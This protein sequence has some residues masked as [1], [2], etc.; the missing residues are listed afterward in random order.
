MRVMVIVKAS[1][2]SEAGLMP[3][4]E[5]LLAM[6]RFNEELMCAGVLLAGEGLHP[7]AK[8]L[9]MR[10]SGL[11]R[12]VMEGPFAPAEDQIAGFW[13][14]Q[15]ENMEE[16]QAWARRCPNPMREGGVLEI[17][18]VFEAADFGDALTPEAAGLHGLNQ[19]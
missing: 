11:H 18:P 5:E 2:E 16:A 13:V 4:T 15:V 8:G 14:W 6:G 12:S 7:T 9:R 19:G 1:A 10:F 17:R 3:S